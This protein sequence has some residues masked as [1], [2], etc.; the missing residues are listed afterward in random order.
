[1]IKLIL[2]LL[3]SPSVYAFPAAEG[4]SAISA[5]ISVLGVTITSLLP[6]NSKKRKSKDSVR[7]VGFFAL[8]SF[9]LLLV[10][11]SYVYLQSS[12]YT[13][14]V[15]RSNQSRP[16][17]M[18][19]G[20]LK[21]FNSKDY[22]S[23]NDIKE[24]DLEEYYNEN[25][26]LR[27][28]YAEYLERRVNGYDLISTYYP[29]NGFMKFPIEV[30]KV[31]SSDMNDVISHVSESKNKYVYASEIP[32]FSI[33]GSYITYKELGIKTP[34]LNIGIQGLRQDLSPERN[35]SLYVNDFDLFEMEPVDIRNQREIRETHTVF[36]ARNLSSLSILLMT[37]R[38]IKEAI[39]F[40]EK[41]VFVS[42][43]DD[44]R[45]RLIEQ[46]LKGMNVP[47]KFL[48]GGL[49]EGH[50]FKGDGNSLTPEY[51]GFAKEVSAKKAMEL[52]VGSQSIYFICTNEGHCSQDLP[53][54]RTI[55]IDFHKMSI[56]KREFFVDSLDSRNKYIIVSDNQE[57]A[58]NAIILGYYFSK[59]D[60]KL[61]GNLK[62]PYF[63]SLEY[64]TR[65]MLA[66]KYDSLEHY[67]GDDFVTMLAAKTEL[68]MSSA[69]ENLGSSI[70]L[71][72]LMGLLS[73]II[74][75]PIQRSTFAGYYAH[76]PSKSKV[77]I[78]AIL[79]FLFVVSIYQFT[80][81]LSATHAVPMSDIVILESF[82]DVLV[83]VFGG[84]L[85]LQAFLSFST[86]KK[87]AGFMVLV[88]AF[89]LHES[90]ISAIESPTLLVLT[91][92]EAV[93]VLFQ[94][95]YFIGFRKKLYLADKGVF[96]DKFN[97]IKPQ[98][99]KWFQTIDYVD[100]SKKGYLFKH[101]SYEFVLKFLKDDVDYILRSC[102]DSIFEEKMAGI[103]DS[104][105]CKK[106]DIRNNIERLNLSHYWIQEY[107]KAECYG[108]ASSKPT[109]DSDFTF[110]ESHKNNA[111]E[112][113]GQEYAYKYTDVKIP[114]AH[115]DL[116]ERIDKIE[117]KLSSYVNIEYC[118]K[119]NK[120]YILQVR[121]I[122]NK[123]ADESSIYPRRMSE[124]KLAESFMVN[125]S[126]ITGSII[127]TVTGGDYKFIGS[128]LFERKNK[129][130]KKLLFSQAKIDNI[131]I[132]LN[133]IE[134]KIK[135]NSINGIQSEVISNL[136][137]IYSDVYRLTQ[138]LQNSDVV[139][140]VPEIVTNGSGNDLDLCTNKDISDRMVIIKGKRDSLHYLSLYA[141]ALI[142]KVVRQLISGEI[143]NYN[144]LNLSE[145]IIS[146][147]GDYKMQLQD[148]G[149][150]IKVIVDGDFT[151]YLHDCNNEY[152][153]E[154]K[155]IV[156]GEEVGSSWVKRLENVGAIISAYGHKLS[157]LSITAKESNIPY[158]VVGAKN[159]KK[160][161]TIN[162]ENKISIKNIKKML[163]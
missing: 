1:M 62:T 119:D 75:L 56:A 34:W 45:Y 55:K 19:D 110:L 54:D 22:L 71:L 67:R 128:Y 13:E 17:L 9:V 41:T 32:F 11:L 99:G 96:I 142:E 76:E 127:E 84:L 60:K 64:I 3:I 135:R 63:F 24:G 29:E 77:I 120:V 68:I 47:F 156:I 89:L 121:K 15:E 5:L 112:G 104:F 30:S 102:D 122:Y 103:N 48:K 93:A 49:G 83:V 81:Y 118:I 51:F 28:T 114:A 14:L 139:I 2:L 69:S 38:E 21:N 159:Y 79:V 152:L 91:V 52:Y 66:N 145:G 73:R 59:S 160:L 131:L 20:G 4:A 163:S 153:E 87:M 6:S 146:E 36:N 134:L 39:N 18:I 95:P 108:V 43:D 8:I 143:K 31:A 150:D 90:Y 86:D 157:H 162:D 149:S 129:G 70:I 115:K 116:I 25:K 40:S 107:V 27:L 58:G 105:I 65:E 82:K 26:N 123:F 10:S 101:S 37:D 72:V 33:V 117:K 137:L 23:D 140:S 42:Y 100:P 113:I 80:N 125:C 109:F 16:D 106:G 44:Y 141:T 35:E 126:P 154:E 148:S 158:I 94:V 46:R 74:I 136:L 161:E 97:G 7:A 144:I 61:L 155:V 124:F 130:F 147:A 98:P 53:K 12:N 78:S 151:G 92:G 85:I 50:F 111:T 88:V 138:S 57:T 132:Q 133:E